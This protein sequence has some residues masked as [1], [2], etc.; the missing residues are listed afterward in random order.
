[1]ATFLSTIHRIKVPQPARQWTSGCWPRK[2]K[3]PGPAPPRHA[4]TRGPAG[5]GRGSNLLLLQRFLHYATVRDESKQLSANKQRKARRINRRVNLAIATAGATIIFAFAAIA[6]QSLAGGTGASKQQQARSQPGPAECRTRS[7]RFARPQPGGCRA[8]YG[9]LGKR[10]RLA[11][12][13]NWP[14]IG[15]RAQTPPSVRGQRAEVGDGQPDVVRCGGKGLGT[16]GH[17]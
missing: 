6:C 5:D 8:G 11:R 3:A 15:R 9:R 16:D 10:P 12:R 13:R 1:M 14:T 2:D 4:E 7:G 17:S